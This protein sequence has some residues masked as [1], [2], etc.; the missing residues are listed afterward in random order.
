MV[1]SG[2]SIRE[3]PRLCIMCRLCYENTRLSVSY[4][5]EEFRLLRAMSNPTELALQI[6]YLRIP[7]FCRQSSSN[8]CLTFL[9]FKMALPKMHVTRENITTCTRCS[10]LF[11]PLLLTKNNSYWDM[12]NSLALGSFKWNLDKSFQ[13]NFSD[14]GLGYLLCNCV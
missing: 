4:G 6:G 10:G 5:N 8:L 2:H 9:T 12:V 3:R 14:W 7:R 11:T 13:A 1:W